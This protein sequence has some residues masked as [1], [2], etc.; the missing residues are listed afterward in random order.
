VTVSEACARPSPAPGC[1]RV[2]ATLQNRGG[3]GEVKVKARLQD[4]A[5]GR[6]FEDGRTVD[7]NAHERLDFVLDVPSPPGDYAATVTAAWPPD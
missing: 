7:L 1:T 2:E 3:R 4:R 6:V 5:T